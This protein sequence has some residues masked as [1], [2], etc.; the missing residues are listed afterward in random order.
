[1]T[2]I[3]YAHSQ[4]KDDV[5]GIVHYCFEHGNIHLNV[6]IDTF[7]SDNVVMTVL[8]VSFSNSSDYFKLV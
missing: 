5:M 3:R 8:I 1:M 2:P 7:F 6:I 4:K